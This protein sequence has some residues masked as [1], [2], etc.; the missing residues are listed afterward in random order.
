MRTSTSRGCWTT[1]AIRNWSEPWDDFFHNYYLYKDY[2]GRWSLVPWDLDREFGEN[3]GWNARKSFFIGERGDPDG[4]NGEW[5][6][7][8]DAFIRAYRTELLARMD[9]LATDDPAS[10]DPAKGVLSPRRFRAAV[11]TAAT[12][13]DAADWSASPVTS[14]CNFGQEKTSL[15]N[16][17]DERHSALMDQLACAT[18]SCGLKGEYFKARSFNNSDL[19]LTRTDRVVQFDWGTAAPASRHAH[20]QLP[21][22]LDRDGH[23][24]VQPD[25]HLLHAVGRRRPPVGQQPAGHRRLDQPHLA[26]GQRHHRPA[27]RPGLQRAPRVLRQRQQRPRSPSAGPAPPR[28]SSWS[29]AGCSPRR[30]E[31]AGIHP[32]RPAGLVSSSSRSTTVRSVGRGRH[33]EVLDPRMFQPGEVLVAHL[34]RLLVRPCPD[35][36]RARLGE[37]LVHHHGHAVQR[38]RTVAR[39]RCQSR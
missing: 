27:G 39:R 16:F 12:R 2:A 38:S 20:R 8:K 30:P 33:R 3:F 1:V 17:G 21:D 25:L 22:P 9:Y 13:F 18:R 34:D 24:G 19:Q 36:H 37:P 28:P 5:N 32:D 6:R 10:S 4:R 35:D 11:D 23:A 14:L 26:R 31:P 7:I 15:Q 29:R